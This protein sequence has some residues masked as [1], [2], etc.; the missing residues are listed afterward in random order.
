MSRNHTHYYYTFGAATSR[1]V[2]ETSSNISCQST[3]DFDHIGAG[4]NFCIFVTKPGMTYAASKPSTYPI[5]R[6]V[7]VNMQLTNAVVIDKKELDVIFDFE[8]G[9]SSAEPHA[10]RRKE[11][12]V[13]KNEVTCATLKDMLSSKGISVNQGAL[14]ESPSLYSPFHRSKTD[15]YMYHEHFYKRQVI[16]SMVASTDEEEDE[17]DMEMHTM[18]GVCEMKNTKKNINQL[19]ANM[20]HFGVQI[21]VKALKEGEIIDCCII[22]G[23]G[24]HY[25]DKSARFL[26]MVMDFN[27]CNTTV[28]DFGL[29]ELADAFNDV[30]SKILA[31]D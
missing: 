18:A 29:F 8:L 4:K 26:K 11:N 2:V 13:S 10:K 5:P 19:I 24:V 6:I 21:T 17:D 30:I 28:E 22:Y 31:E 15:L 12:E 16:N 27:N 9:I 20:T 1:R 14:D 3:K 7:K 23:L 25:S